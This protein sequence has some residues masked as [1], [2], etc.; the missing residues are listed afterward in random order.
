MFASFSL[1]SPY[2]GYVP[3]FRTNLFVFQLK[4][5]QAYIFNPIVLEMRVKTQSYSV[6]VFPI[7]NTQ[8]LTPDIV[9]F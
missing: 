6:K 2:K 4:L 5:N 7:Q 1:T 9:Q 8:N 3:T